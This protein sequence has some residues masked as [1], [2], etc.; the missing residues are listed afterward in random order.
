MS[1]TRASLRTITAW[2]MVGVFL[3]LAVGLTQEPE[4]LESTP[5]EVHFWLT[6]LYNNDGESQLINAGSGLEDFGGVARFATLVHQLK[7]EVTAH[8]WHGTQPSS[9]S[10]R[11]V[12]MVSSGDNF[13]RGAAEWPTQLGADHGE[14]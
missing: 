8:A 3:H 9:G 1:A 5:G 12:I 14:Q 13:L 2:S 10:K 4:T 6:L 11:G 7:Q